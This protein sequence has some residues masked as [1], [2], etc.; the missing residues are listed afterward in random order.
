MVRSIIGTGTIEFFENV[1]NLLIDKFNTFM[2]G[3]ERSRS[4]VEIKKIPHTKY[5]TL[6]LN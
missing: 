2:N 4:A 6:K 1:L 5:S 3:I